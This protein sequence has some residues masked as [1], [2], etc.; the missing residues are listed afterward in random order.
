MAVSGANIKERKGIFGDFVVVEFGDDEL[1]HFEL[2]VGVV[3]PTF[4]G[5]VIGME[6]IDFSLVELVPAI[7]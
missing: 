1:D 6:V 7:C 4:A 5:V 3:E 2:G